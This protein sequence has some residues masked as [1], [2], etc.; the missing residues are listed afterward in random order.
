MKERD[1]WD[2]ITE[3]ILDNSEAYILVTRVDGT[4]RIEEEGDP[5]I[6]DILK[7]NLIADG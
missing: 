2:S 1:I 7:L 5:E 6:I 3:T 4:I